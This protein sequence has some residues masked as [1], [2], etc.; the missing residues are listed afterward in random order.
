MSSTKDPAKGIGTRC[1]IKVSLIPEEKKAYSVTFRNK[2]FRFD[3]KT[4]GSLETC[5]KIFGVNQGHLLATSMSSAAKRL[6]LH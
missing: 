1:P 3:A 6:S 2:S 5:I 4:K